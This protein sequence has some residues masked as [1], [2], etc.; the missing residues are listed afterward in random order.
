LW[1]AILAAERDDVTV[2]RATLDGLPRDRLMR[3]EQLLLGSAISSHERRKRATERAAQARA[4]AEAA[5]GAGDASPAP[6]PP[7]PSAGGE[8]TPVRP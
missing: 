1:T 6:E 5:A 4:E 8:A 2:L 3:E 7:I